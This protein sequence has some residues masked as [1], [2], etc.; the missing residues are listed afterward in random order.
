MNKIKFSLINH[1]GDVLW[2]IRDEDKV[3]IYDQWKELVD[4]MSVELFCTWIDGTI[5]LTDSQGKTWHWNKEHREAKP[6]MFKL[7]NF[8]N[9]N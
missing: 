9:N 1:E 2:A 4:I 3:V 6:N 8:L 7:L 5:G